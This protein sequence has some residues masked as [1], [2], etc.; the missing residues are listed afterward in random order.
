MNASGGRDL[1]VRCYD[2]RDG[3]QLAERRVS[4]PF[5]DQ[6]DLSQN[7]SPVQKPLLRLDGDAALV[8]VWDDRI[9]K[10]VVYRLDLSGN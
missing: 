9:G 2:L 4:S 3:T 6:W 5:G 1:L 10:V 8:N 7:A